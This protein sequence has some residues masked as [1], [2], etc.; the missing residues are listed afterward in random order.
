MY[1]ILVGSPVRQ[2]SNILKEF[3][4]GL[5]EADKGQHQIAYYFVDDNVEAASSE[6]LTAFAEKHD[7]K[8]KKGSE[9]YDADA[10]YEGHVWHATHL[11][12]V[13]GYKTEI[14]A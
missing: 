10:H 6:L 9:L 5:E 4:L 1:R 11:A 3:L 13:T 2:K 7:V 8:L 12:Q 14:I